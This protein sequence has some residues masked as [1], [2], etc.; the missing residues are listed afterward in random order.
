MSDILDSS[1]IESLKSGGGSNAPQIAKV[2]AW[3]GAWFEVVGTEVPN[4]EY[5]P[6]SV[7]H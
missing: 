6:Q 7:A 2:K 5:T 4:F 3:F 1:T